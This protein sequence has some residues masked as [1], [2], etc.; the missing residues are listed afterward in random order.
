M[1]GA[2]Q[3][4]IKKEVARELVGLS[5]QPFHLGQKPWENMSVLYLSSHT[6]LMQVLPGDGLADPKSHCV[7]NRKKDKDRHQG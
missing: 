4:P 1:E 5:R 2:V 3:K 7:A 6:G